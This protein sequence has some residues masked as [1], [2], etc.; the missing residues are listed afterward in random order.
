M[1]LISEYWQV[2]YYV[3]GE[4]RGPIGDKTAITP[5]TQFGSRGAAR[6]RARVL[7]QGSPKTITYKV[8]HIRRYRVAKP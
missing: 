8:V 7:R 3:N 1:H 5:T 2:I 6:F 4:R